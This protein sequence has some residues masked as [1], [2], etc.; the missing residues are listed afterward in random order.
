MFRELMHG[1]VN[2]RFQELNQ[3]SILHKNRSGK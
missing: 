2:A 1:L 3:Y